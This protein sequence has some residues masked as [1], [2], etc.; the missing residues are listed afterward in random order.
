MKRIFVIYL[1]LFSFSIFSE[2]LKEEKE[3]TETANPPPQVTEK[4]KTETANPPP[5][6]TE[7]EKTETANPPPQVTEKEKTE[8]VNPPP[9]VT[10]KEKTETANPPPQVTEKEKTETVNPPPQVT[11]KEKTETVNPP[12]QVTEG[13]K[14]DKKANYG[15]FGIWALKSGWGG[16]RIEN[17]SIQEDQGGSNSFRISGEYNPRYFGLE[18]GVSYFK[19][20]LNPYTEFPNGNPFDSRERFSLTFFDIAPTLHIRPGKIFDPYLSIG[21]GIAGLSYGSANRGFGRL[22]FRINLDR[23]FLF[24]ETEA[25]T[26]NRTYSQDLKFNYNEYSGIFGVGIYFGVDGG[27]DRKEESVKNPSPI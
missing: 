25:S 5:Q 17:S 20:S 18:I 9:Q 13:K 24:A 21:G 27:S 4:E 12:P 22:G 8:T 19:F 6:V 2:T 16:G 1:L 26:I 10:E 15:Q 23:I 7:K 11:E 14:E 3:K